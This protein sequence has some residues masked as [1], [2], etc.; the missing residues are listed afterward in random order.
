MTTT[1]SQVQALACPQG[2]PAPPPAENNEAN[3]PQGNPLTTGWMHAITNLMGFRL[4]FE[5]GQKLQKL[6]LYQNFFNHTDL[7]VTWD[8]IEFEVNSN[9]Q[10]YPEPDGTFSYLHPNLVEQLV[11]LR[12]YM[13]RPFPYKGSISKFRDQINVSP[14]FLDSTF[15]QNVNYKL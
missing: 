8:P 11:G 6:V 9:Y 5:T 14:N 12:N 2:A 13:L 7:A 4:T 3:P 15:R 10:K 1:W